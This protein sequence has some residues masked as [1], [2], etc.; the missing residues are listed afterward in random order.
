[1]KTLHP[2]RLN[3]VTTGLNEPIHSTS[4]ID[5]EESEMISFSLLPVDKEDE[6]EDDEDSDEKSGRSKI[7]FSKNKK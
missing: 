7:I 2:S 3:V 5:E 1:M 6:D 4:F